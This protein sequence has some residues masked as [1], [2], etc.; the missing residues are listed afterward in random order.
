MS[1]N[2]EPNPK[3]PLASLWVSAVVVGF[4]IFNILGSRAVQN[5]LHK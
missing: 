5:L 4:L 1:E 3:F 2:P